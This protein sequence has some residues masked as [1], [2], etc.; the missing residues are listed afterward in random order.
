VDLV[1]GI[2]V[3]GGM[4]KIIVEGATG[5]YDTNYEGKA[6]AALEACSRHD[7]VYVHVEATDE[8]GHAKDLELKI[9]CIEYLDDRLVRHILEGIEKMSEPV[10]V[11]VLPDHPTPVETGQHA[12]DPVP[13]AVWQPGVSPDAVQGYDEEQAK[14]GSLGL[15]HKDQFFR[16]A[17]GL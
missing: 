3:L 12:S 14:H 4:E 17:I 6:A 15:L 2:G 8:A 1:Q 11:S 16:R 13:V 7:V 10:A 5:L 9:K